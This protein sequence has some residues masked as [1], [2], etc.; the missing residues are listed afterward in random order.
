MCIFSL[1]EIYSFMQ[2]ETNFYMNQLHNRWPLHLII[3]QLWIGFYIRRVCTLCTK[4]R[5]TGLK[6]YS[7]RPCYGCMCFPFFMSLKTEVYV[8]IL[9]ISWIFSIIRKKIT[10]MKWMPLFFLTSKKF[11]NEEEEEIF[12]LTKILHV[13]L[14]WL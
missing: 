9:K 2:I 13:S 8:V 5:F 10:R 11:F 12:F 14:H 1:Y 6:I 7:V 3:V 4:G